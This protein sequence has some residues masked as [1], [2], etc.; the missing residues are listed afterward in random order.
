MASKP[1]A[2]HF[3]DGGLNPLFDL[4]LRKCGLCWGGYSEN[5]TPVELKG[6]T[7]F[8]DGCGFGYIGYSLPKH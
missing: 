6:A 1:G 2:T 7:L 3:G 8:D 5:F 4:R